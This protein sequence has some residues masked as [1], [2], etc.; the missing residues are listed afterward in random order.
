MVCRKTNLIYENAYRL[1]CLLF[2]KRAVA[3]YEHYDNCFETDY[4]GSYNT[5]AKENSIMFI[6]VS[7]ANVKYL[8]YCKKAYHVNEFKIRML[9]RKESIILNYFKNLCSEKRMG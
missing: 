1:F 7:S 2:D 5:K 9:Y 6:M 4:S 3:H 8:K